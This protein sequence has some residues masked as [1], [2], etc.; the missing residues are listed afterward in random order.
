MTLRDALSLMMSEGADPLVVVDS[1]G[2]P[3]G[4]ISVA[5]VG[6]LLAEL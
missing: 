2:A 5:R 4:L 3:L 6:Q 1:E